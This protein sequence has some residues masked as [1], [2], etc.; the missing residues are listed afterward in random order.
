VSLKHRYSFNETTGTTVTDSVSGANGTVSGAGVFA[1]GELT[2]DGVDAYVDLPN[3]IISGLGADG[4]IELWITHQDTDRWARIFDFGISDAGEDAAGGGVDFLFF[5]PRTGDGFPRFTANFPGGGDLVNLIPAPPGWI[6]ANEQ[7][8]I[9][10]TW[11]SSG[12]TSR[13]FIDGVPYATGTAPQP[14]SALAG[15]DLNNWLGRSQFTADPNW[16]G[17]YNEVRL[18]TGAMTPSQVQASFAAGPTGTPVAAPSL[19]VSKSGTTLTIRWPASATGFALES[20]PAL[21]AT[22]NWTPVT[23][24]TTSGSDMQVSVPIAAGNRFFRLR[25]P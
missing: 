9:V 8:H 19:S 7:K 6:P 1:G 17:K 22:A 13:M 10:I 16:A 2:L 12:N 23:G 14:L 25:R 3:G 21:G 11:S 5:T 4:T 20:S 24:A 15:Q 18:H